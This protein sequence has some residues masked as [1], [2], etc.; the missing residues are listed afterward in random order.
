VAKLVAWRRGH[1]SHKRNPT[2]SGIAATGQSVN[3][4]QG[5]D[6]GGGVFIS[7][8]TV[9]HTTEQLRKLFTRAKLWGVHFN[10]EPKWVKH[11]L[12]VPAER[13]R[14][15]SDDEADKLDAATR[16]DLAPFFAFAR[17]SGLR[18]RECLLRWNEVQRD[19]RQIVKLGKGDRW[20]TVSIT[21][22]I[23]DILWPLQGHHPEHVFTFVAQRT[24]DGRVRGQRHP[25]TY[26]FVQTYWQHLCRKAGVV[27]FRFHDYRHDLGSKVLRMT[28][29]LK[30]AQRVLNHRDI[31]STLRYAHVLDSEVA[32][33]LER[34]AKS[35]SKP[36]R[37][38]REVG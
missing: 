30:L 28:G 32:D 9:N 18:L 16:E 4:L 5:T 34:V 12:S 29:N 25:L 15:L 7:P 11:L 13:V 17:A 36:R 26:H 33:A 3:V 24:R 27:G 6:A 10:R 19:T 23:R 35:R 1:R 38:L 21:P 31:K 14:E 22:S 2:N 8:H 37:H 20:V